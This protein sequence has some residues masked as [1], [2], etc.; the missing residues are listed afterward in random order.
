MITFEQGLASLPNN[1]P[2][3]A[4]LRAFIDTNLFELPVYLALLF[5]TLRWTKPLLAGLAVNTLT[6]PT[7][8]YLVPYWDVPIPG[9]A[10]VA[11]RLA[12]E[13]SLPPEESGAYLGWVLVVE[14]GV[15]LVEGLL[16]GLFLRSFGR[17]PEGERL[18]LRPCLA[19]GM[20]ASLLANA[21]STA[22]GLADVGLG[23]LLV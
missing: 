22:M 13:P 16:I 3:E 12:V 19:Y 9:F 15:V 2:V 4:W 5:L 11:S 1:H 23:K 21:L 14:I 8:W 10:H 17:A 18:P 7:L 20:L 6:H